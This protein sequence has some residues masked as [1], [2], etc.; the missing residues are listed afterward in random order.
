MGGIEVFVLPN[1]TMLLPI[2][3]K[4][5]W[6]NLGQCCGAAAAGNFLLEF[7][8]SDL[9]LP[10]EFKAQAQNSA[11][12][13]AKA[14]VSH[15]QQERGSFV[16]PSAEEHAK[17]FDTRWQSGWMQ[18]AAGIAS[19]LLHIHAVDVGAHTGMRQFWPDEPWAGGERVK[20]TSSQIV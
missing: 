6:Q 1:L 11:R 18:G 8:Q 9:P 2:G 4:G 13:I 7:S 14:I 5:A 20:L 10:A 12:Q 3:E 16:L 19:F 15:A 17:P